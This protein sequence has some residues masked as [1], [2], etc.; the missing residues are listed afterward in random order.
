MNKILEATYQNGILM[1]KEKL[2]SNFEG[3]KVKI[4]LIDNDE[5]ETKKEMFFKLASQHSGKLPEDYKFDR[6]EIY[7][8]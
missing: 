4:M 7:E 1:L 6:E 8:K 3:K 5:S 2:S